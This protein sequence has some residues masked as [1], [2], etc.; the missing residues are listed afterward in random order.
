MLGA[1]QSLGRFVHGEVPLGV[2]AAPSLLSSAWG[3]REGPPNH[4]W[5]SALYT[6][7][8]VM[9]M[10]RFCRIRP[11]SLVRNEVRKRAPP[12]RPVPPLRGGKG[13]AAD[14]SA[15]TQ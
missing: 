12:H 4:D 5:S 15:L 13:G 8:I 1:G 2:V 3:G 11:A 6:I 14:Q 9:E 10:H 7:A